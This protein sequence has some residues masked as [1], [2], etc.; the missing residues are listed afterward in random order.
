MYGWLTP[1]INE[2]IEGLDQAPD[3]ADNVSFHALIFGNSSIS[4]RFWVAL[5]LQFYLKLLHR[6]SNLLGFAMSRR[7]HTSNGNGGVE[8]FNHSIEQVL[9]MVPN[10][11]QGN[12]DAELP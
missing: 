2:V 3:Y 6:L 11:R 12:W 7:A 10:V 5:H 1:M 4:I 8:R 9:G